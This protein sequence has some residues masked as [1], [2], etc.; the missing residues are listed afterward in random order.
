MERRA[1]FKSLAT[2]AKKVTSS[3]CYELNV[4]NTNVN[5]FIKN[6]NKPIFIINSNIF[7]FSNNSSI[8][9]CYFNGNYTKLISAIENQFKND[10][11]LISN[12]YLKGFSK[13]ILINQESTNNHFE[14]TL[15]AYDYN[16][17]S[18]AQSYF[19][20]QSVNNKDIFVS[21]LFHDNKLTEAFIN[22][23]KVF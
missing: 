13:Y 9:F 7:K 21:Q 5:I 23:L 15:F 8:N 1:F 4:D 11:Y 19:T 20:Q 12:Q 18:T 3:N 14:E 16:Y 17:I 10:I 22:R 6:P 2:K